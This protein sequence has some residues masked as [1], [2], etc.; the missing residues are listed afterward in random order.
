MGQVIV[1]GWDAGGVCGRVAERRLADRN[2]IRL[3]VHKAKGPKQLIKIELFDGTTLL[4]S[5]EV[6]G[7]LIRFEPELVFSD[8][9][10]PL[11][12]QTDPIKQIGHAFA[13]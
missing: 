11:S 8:T 5:D 3:I 2:N 4:R 13:D 10:A 1:W 6:D 9:K 12:T 7:A